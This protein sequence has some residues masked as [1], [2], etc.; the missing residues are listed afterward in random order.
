MGTLG[1]GKGAQGAWVPGG[2]QGGGG[3]LVG[4]SLRSL[5]QGCNPLSLLPSRRFSRG[6]GVVVVARVTWHLPSP[7]PGAGCPRQGRPHLLQVREGGTSSSTG[8]MGEEGEEGVEVARAAWWWA[9][10]S[11]SLAFLA[12]PR[13]FRRRLAGWVMGRGVGSRSCFQVHLRST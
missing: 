1:A 11:L 13:F 5:A 7:G 9:A 8:A 4:P 12:G 3:E 6:G 2:G 10:L